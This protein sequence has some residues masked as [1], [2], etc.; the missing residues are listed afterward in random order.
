MK[1]L[2][3]ILISVIII[4]AL[5]S[6]YFYYFNNSKTQQEGI[7][8]SLVDFFPSSDTKI[9]NTDGSISD[10]STTG[11][12]NVSLSQD[13]TALTTKFQQISEN[14]IAGAAIVTIKATSAKALPTSVV[15]L[16]EKATGYVFSYDQGTAKKQISN[17]TWV[18]G[19]EVYWG[20]VNASPSFILRRSKNSS[21]ENFL[22][23]LSGAGATSS[24]PGILS[25]INLDSNISAF[26]S[27]PK[28]DRYFYL[29]SS[30]SGS[31]GYLAN[32]NQTSVPVQIFSSPYS[33]WKVSW[34]EENTIIF[35]S[36]PTADQP[37]LVYALNIKSKSFTRILGGV[38]GLTSLTSP[39]GQKIVYS[40]GLSALRIKKIGKEGSEIDLS[41]A[42]LPEKCVWSKDSVRIFCSV[43]NSIPFGN[44]PDTWYQGLV[45]FTDSIWE[46]NTLTGA[47][48]Q[49]YSPASAAEKYQIDGINLF[50]SKDETKLFLTN[51]TD[52]TLWR[53][54]LVDQA[55][56]VISVSSSTTATTTQ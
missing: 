37:G 56:F 38:L 47:N 12:E 32:F 29:V 5:L 4:F 39:D 51:K 31:I 3:I 36:A 21:I 10:P 42:T 55:S 45:N 1:K 8:K 17:T 18:G 28:K 11:G 52:Y 54:L 46:I 43:P 16:I 6:G 35:Q 30:P 48:R 27:S 13:N 2:S 9:I 50:L 25:G 34:P 7:V 26:T 44:Y 53:L 49:I 22:A 24:Q 23:H 33:Q 19:Q 41:L 40:G 20:E 14:P 15:W